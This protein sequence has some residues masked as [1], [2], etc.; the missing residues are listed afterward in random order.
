MFTEARTYSRWRDQEVSDATLRRLYELAKWPPTSM[1]ANPLRLV[2]V[3]SA[4]AKQRLLPALAPGNVEKMLRAPVTAIVAADPHF[5]ERLPHLFP[6]AAAAREQFAAKPDWAEETAFRNSSMQGGYLIL[7]ARALGL[8]C[9][10]MSGFDCARVDA[11][12]FADNGYR[13]NFLVNIGHGA[14]GGVYPRG[15][16]L[17]FETVVRIL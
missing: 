2:F 6:A 17:P 8:D 12:F 15:P 11:E 14:A 7:A 9:G 5:Y 16:R 3:K 10:P 13:S 1:N 4:A